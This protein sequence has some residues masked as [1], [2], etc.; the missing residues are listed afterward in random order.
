MSQLISKLLEDGLEKIGSRRTISQVKR[1]KNSSYSFLQT[2]NLK[3][4]AQTIPN[5]EAQEIKCL[6]VQAK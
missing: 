2:M 5:Q 6:Q 4:M 3:I 1:L